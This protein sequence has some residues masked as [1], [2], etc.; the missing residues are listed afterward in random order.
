MSVKAIERLAETGAF[1]PAEGFA[2]LSER[3]VDF[4]QLVGGKKREAALGKLLQRVEPVKVAVRGPSG[5]GKSSMIAATLADLYSHLPLPIAIASADIGIL[6]SQTLFGQFIIREIN[7]QAKTKFAAQAKPGWRQ[8]RA[9]ARVAETAAADSKTRQRGGAK[10]SGTLG[11][12]DYASIAIEVT[13]AIT[14]TTTLKNPSQS[15]EGLAELAR[16]FKPKGKPTP[17]L[18]IDDADKWASST[19]QADAEKRAQLLFSTALQPLLTLPMHIV[20]AV[21]DHWIELAQYENLSK[22]LTQTIEIPDFTGDALG[23]LR[24]IV[25]HRITDTDGVNEHLGALLDDSALVRLEAEY[26]HRDRSIRHV[27]RVLD[28]AIKNA[29]DESPVPERL[30]HVHLRHAARQLGS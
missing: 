16:V 7:R 1:E 23:P 4:D 8:K 30:T 9:L 29:A 5:S 10:A 22:R 27:L 12:P 24:E 2:E 25:A 15:L 18:I 21:Q 26:D 17:V 11:V 6:E 19:D 3:H 14:S 20:V 28:V 13:T